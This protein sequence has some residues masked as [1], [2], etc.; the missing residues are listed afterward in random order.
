MEIPGYPDLIP[1]RAQ[2]ATITSA[3]WPSMGRIYQFLSTF[4]HPY[5]RPDGTPWPDMR[6]IGAK[7]IYSP[8]DGRTWC[9]QDGSTPVVWAPGRERSR[10]TLVFFE[11]DQEAFS[12]SCRLL[13]MG[14]NYEKS[15]RIRLRL[16]AE[17][18][19]RRH[20]ER[21]R[22]VP[23]AQGTASQSSAYEYFAG[24]RAGWPRGLGEGH[25]GTREVV[26]T[27]PRGWVGKVDHPWAGCPVSPITRRS[28]C[29]MMAS[30][31]MGTRRTESGSTSPATWA[32]GSAQPMGSVD[33]I[34]EETAWMPGGDPVRAHLRRRLRRN[35][36]R[37]TASPSGSY[38]R[39]TRTTQRNANRSHHE[40]EHARGGPT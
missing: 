40:R 21:A 4:N 36:S 11:E 12:C 26:H 24:L 5:E 30:W 14:R 3:L 19:Y 1:A 37:R 18:K 34:H 29:Y 22:H 15:R 23:G 35:G 31:G 6:F 38:G 13:Q 33:Q 17:W 32:F 7:L 27:F 16:R 39:T 20:D 25:I 9:N 2:R 28:D 10:E 8:D